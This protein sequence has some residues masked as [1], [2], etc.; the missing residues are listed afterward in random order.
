VIVCEGDYAKGT[1]PMVLRHGQGSF[2]D[3]NGNLV[4]RGGWDRD[5]CIPLPPPMPP[6][7]LPQQRVNASQLNAMSRPFVPAIQENLHAAMLTVGMAHQQRMCPTPTAGPMH[8]NFAPSPS[9][10]FL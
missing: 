9:Y 6:P 10:H 2:H 3:A 4:H 5:Q 1:L 7:P 8:K